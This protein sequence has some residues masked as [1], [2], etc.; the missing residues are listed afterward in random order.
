[1]EADIQAQF[2]ALRKDNQ[3][4]RKEVR[5]DIKGLHAKLDEHTAAIGKRCARRGEEL[6]VLKNRDRERDR[7][8]D[9]RVGIGLLIIA[10]VSLVLKFAI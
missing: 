3:I 4:L 6:A 10:A 9:V 8:V 7:R 5:A 2:R 1:M